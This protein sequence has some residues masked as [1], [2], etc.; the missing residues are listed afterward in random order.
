[1]DGRTMDVKK[2]DIK[3]IDVVYSLDR[4]SKEKPESLLLLFSTLLIDFKGLNVQESFP[5]ND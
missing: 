1:M 4:A 2:G 5:E 3:E